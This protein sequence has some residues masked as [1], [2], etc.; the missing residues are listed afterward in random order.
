MNRF[1]VLVRETGILC[2]L[3]FFEFV[4]LHQGRVSRVTE[5]SGLKK[6]TTGMQSWWCPRRIQS[7]C[8]GDI[9][10]SVV[11]SCISVLRHSSRPDAASF[12]GIIPATTHCFF[13]AIVA[14]ENLLSGVL[15]LSVGPVKCR[16]LS[17][18]EFVLWICS[19]CGSGKARDIHGDIN[20]WYHQGLQSVACRNCGWS[21]CQRRFTIRFASLKHRALGAVVACWYNR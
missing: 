14:S 17:F 20:T 1:S 7:L 3:C 18:L 15:S 19:V 6:K 11:F 9:G 8:P 5:C 4:H 16:L 13:L 21:A 10:S 2:L 12:F